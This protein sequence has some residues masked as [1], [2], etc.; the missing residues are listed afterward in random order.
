MKNE[1]AKAS[2]TICERLKQFVCALTGIPNYQLAMNMNTPNQNLE[3]RWASYLKSA[4]WISPAL[5]VWMACCVF[6]VPKLKDVGEVSK[7]ELP[8]LIRFQLVVA[9]TIRMNFLL[10]ALI[11]LVSLFLLEWRWRGWSR[12]RR[13]LLGIMGFCLNF[14]TFFFLASLLVYAVLVAAHLESHLGHPH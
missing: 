2:E 13:L 7:T 12:Y 11:F 4:V 6:V 5:F 9:D 1:F 8:E 14:F 10:V 3:P